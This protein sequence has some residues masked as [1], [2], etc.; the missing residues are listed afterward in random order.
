M[1]LP[2]LW[3]LAVASLLFIA[4]HN[5]TYA[6]EQEEGEQKW[7]FGLGVG[8]VTGPDYRGSDE[9]RNFV[10]PIPYVVYRGKIIRSDREGVRGNFLRTDLYEFT[11]S[12]SAAI[13]PDT[14]QNELREG[15]PELGSTL[16]LGPSFNINLSGKSFTQGWHVQTPWRAVFSIGA[17]ES[18]YIGSVFQPQLV[19]RNKLGNWAFSY[20]AGVMFASDAYHDYY[21]NVDQQYVTDSRGYFNADGGYSGWN[22]QMALS[23][24]FNHN[25]IRTRLALFIRYD[26]IDGTNFNKSS[27]AVTDHSY[28]GGFAFIWVIK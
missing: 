2:C 23:R 27:L 15:M 28:R 5:A 16:E 8:A 22:N 3:K 12:A 4:T 20:R 21:Y 9:Y 14:D 26:N 19:Y 7:E 11:F 25:G 10:S 1:N 17:D 18:G 13:T 6:Q 24:S